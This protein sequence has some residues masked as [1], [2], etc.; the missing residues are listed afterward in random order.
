MGR[1]LVKLCRSAAFSNGVRLHLCRSYEYANHR[2][3]RLLKGTGSHSQNSA[4][5]LTCQE[6]DCM[7]KASVLSC[8]FLFLLLL[9]GC[10]KS[11]ALQETLSTPPTA[12]SAVQWR[13]RP[14]AFRDNR[15]D[16]YVRKEIEGPDFIQSSEDSL[17]T[18]YYENEQLRIIKIAVYQSRHQV[19][20]RFY[21]FDDDVVIIEDTIIYAT[22]KPLSEIKE[23]DM[24]LDSVLQAVIKDG[25]VYHYID[26]CELMYLSDDT[27]YAEIYTKAVEALAANP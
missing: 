8:A 17:L 11:E 20:L 19:I 2:G 14:Y 10:T 16:V 18:G 7:K 24:R 13:G 5:T 21:P 4:T 3:K 9:W 6:G 23:D 26:E 25:Q 1:R 22:D 27:W 15:L 12:S